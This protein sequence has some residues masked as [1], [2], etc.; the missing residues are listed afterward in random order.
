MCVHAYVSMCV[1]KLSWC[2]KNCSKRVS[3]YVHIHMS[4]NAFT[5]QCCSCYSPD[6]YGVPFD[7]KCTWI[8]T[9][10]HL[11]TEQGFTPKM[12]ARDLSCSVLLSS[13]SKKLTSVCDAITKG[14]L[15]WSCPAKDTPHCKGTPKFSKRQST[16]SKWGNGGAPP[17]HI[18]YYTA[19][20]DANNPIRNTLW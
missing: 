4:K 1:Y 15:K 13:P 16:K 14:I 11:D 18:G 17:F 5:F 20:P 9:I 8:K 19:S 3:V 7:K 10:W 12:E 2:I 6:R